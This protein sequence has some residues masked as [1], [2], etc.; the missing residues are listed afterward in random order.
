MDSSDSK[1]CFLKIALNFASSKSLIRHAKLAKHF[2]SQEQLGNEEKR[3]WW[4]VP[5]LHH[6][7]EACATKKRAGQ[8]ACPMLS[9]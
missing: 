9:N 8:E 4:A 1:E 2:H 7:L 5:T 3:K 6:R